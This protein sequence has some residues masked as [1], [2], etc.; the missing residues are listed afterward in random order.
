[1]EL[2]DWCFCPATGMPV[3]YS[4]YKKKMGIERPETLVDESGRGE[5]EKCAIDPIFGKEVKLHEI[6]KV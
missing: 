4:V 2:E 5:R 6:S 1:M 3:S